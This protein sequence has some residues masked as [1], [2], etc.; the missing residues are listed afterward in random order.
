MSRKRK[1]TRNKN[2]VWDTPTHVW[3]VSTRFAAVV[4]LLVFGV[5]VHAVLKHHCRALNREIGRLESEQ[6]VLMEKLE[7]D[8]IR[9][10]QLKTPE[11]LE[12]ALARHGVAMR[13]PAG[14]QVVHMMPGAVPG[15]YNEQKGRS[16][17]ASR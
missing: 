5:T 11:N 12:T 15:R 6:R 16:A 17:Y 8:R 7:R 9:W 3:V 4:V 2:R 13:Y 10:T 1:R 14:A